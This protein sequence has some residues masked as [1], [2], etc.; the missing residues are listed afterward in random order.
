MK[1]CSRCKQLKKESNFTKSKSRV[2]GLHGHCKDCRRDSRRGVGIAEES[3]TR[4]QVNRARVQIEIGE[5]LSTLVQL[6]G[7]VV[8]GC[9][10]PACVKF[11]RPRLRKV[12]T[13]NLM[14]PTSLGVAKFLATTHHPVCL[15]CK[16]RIE[17]GEDITPL[18]KEKVTW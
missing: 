6:Q 7:C 9:P 18:F 12:G 14:R 1:I 3:S 10:H 5:Y 2:D 11:Y 16:A 17:A 15:N 4:V 8:C 13:L